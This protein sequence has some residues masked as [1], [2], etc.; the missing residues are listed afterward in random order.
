MR[1]RYNINIFWL[2][3]LGLDYLQTIT[4]VVAFLWYLAFSEDQ[5]VLSDSLYLNGCVDTVYLK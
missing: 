1:Q 4:K 5:G 3:A 2:N